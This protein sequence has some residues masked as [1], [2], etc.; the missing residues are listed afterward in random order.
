MMKTNFYSSDPGEDLSII[1][2][3]EIL[4]RLD[5]FGTKSQSKD[6]L[7]SADLKQI[8]NLSDS[9]IYRLRRNKKI[10]Y[11]KLGGK[12][13]YSRRSIEDLLK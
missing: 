3:Y 9:S 2:L 7:D 8:Y 6:L 11:I 13:Y 4:N 10:K 5:N 1:L 12:Y